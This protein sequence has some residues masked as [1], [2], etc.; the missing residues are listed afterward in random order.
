MFFFLSVVCLNL[1]YFKR[2]GNVE[3]QYAL[4][5]SGRQIKKKVLGIYIYIFFLNELLMKH[6]TEINRMHETR[7]KYRDTI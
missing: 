5:T 7:E 1:K 2:E 4:V 3:I 6:Y